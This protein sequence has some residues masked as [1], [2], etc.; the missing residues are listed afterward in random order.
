MTEGGESCDRDEESMP[1]EGKLNPQSA[2]DETG[3]QQSVE[4]KP[5]ASMRE[6]KNDA[7]APS[8]SSER[9]RKAMMKLRGTIICKIELQKNG[10]GKM[11]LE[12]C[13]WKNE[14]TQARI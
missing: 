2:S 5:T 12:K 3:G 6:S 13:V 10:F 14:K 7:Q 8:G 1:N 4:P 11:C 9:A